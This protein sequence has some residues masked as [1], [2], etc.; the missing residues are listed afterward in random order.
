M[1]DHKKNLVAGVFYFR[2]YLA[3]LGSKLRI[4]HGFIQYVGVSA[5]IFIKTL[6]NDVNRENVEFRELFWRR[7]FYDEK[8]YVQGNNAV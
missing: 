2:P 4:P 3:F 1:R 6:Q 5:Q 7:I 8:M